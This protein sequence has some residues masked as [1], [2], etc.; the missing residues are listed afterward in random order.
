MS[1]KELSTEFDKNDYRVK[2][3]ELLLDKM[4]IDLF[5]VSLSQK[6]DS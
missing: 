4:L 2:K 1:E 6:I 3:M 5:I